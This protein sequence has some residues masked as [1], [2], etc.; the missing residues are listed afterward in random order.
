MLLQPRFTFH[1][2]WIAIL[3]CGT[4]FAFSAEEQIATL[5]R[6]T[7]PDWPQ[8]RGPRRDGI[9]EETGLLASWPNGGPRCLW[10]ASG[11][12]KGYS[13]PIVVDGV[14]YIT[15]DQENDLIISAL[16]ADGSLRWQSTNGA[17]W[18]R[19]YPGARSSC[20]Y[21]E[22]RLFHMN[23]H[24]RLACLDAATG[25]EV[26]TVNVLERFDAKNITWGI[27]ESLLVHGHRV[28]VTPA[29]VKG[30]AAALDKRTGATVWATPALD[31]EQASYGPPVL[32]AIGGQRLLVNGGARYAFAVDADSGK[33]CWQV[34]HLDPQNTIT[35]TP[36]LSKDHLIFTNSSRRFGGTYGV[37][38]DGVP[39]ERVWY[40]DL[41]VGHGGLVGVDGL[42]FGASSRGVAT[43]WV[44]IEA[45]T[46]T[47]TRVGELPR[48]SLI[49]ADERFY[50]LSEQGNMTLQEM[51]KDGFRTTGSFQL[52]REKDVWA[53][54]VICRGRLFLRYQDTLFCYDVRR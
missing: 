9:S 43:G 27:S 1:S 11:I 48:G 29:G 34:R 52:A 5:I 30:L 6:S 54:P 40:A 53:H 24:G 44:A 8:W 39:S 14:I 22:G 42:L 38:L 25:T 2:G 7:A 37:R 26:W 45:A 13:S 4:T 49:Y 46:G 20:S 50:C 35:T 47:A 21:D 12:G 16:S 32:I 17:A 10:T 23:A 19:S 31:G 36:V 41:K 18:Q 3:I 33:L 15:G 28:F 51:T